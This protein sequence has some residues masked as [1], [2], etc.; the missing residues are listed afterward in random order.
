MTVILIGASYRDIPLSDLAKLESCIETIRTKL[1][2]DESI[3]HGIDGGVVVSTC[4]RFEIYLD[5]YLP[6]NATAHVIDCIAQAT[7]NS[8]DFWRHGIKVLVGA[9]AI[10]HLF[11]VSAGLDS[12]VVG[13]VEIA[14]QIKRALA[15]TQEL[16]Q[17][18][19]ITEAL[20]QRAALVSKK[21]ANRTNLGATGRSLISSAL[22]L[23]E[24]RH[25][26]LTAKTVL[27][28]GTGAYARVVIAALG[29]EEVG[30][31]FVYSPSGRA[32]EFSK[33]HQTTPISAAQFPQILHRVDL[34]ITCSGTH[35]TLIHTQDLLSAPQLI[36]PMIDLS[37]SPDIEDGVKNLSHVAVINLEEIYR[38]APEEHHETLALAEQII[39]EAVVEFQDDLAA[40]ANDPLVKALRGHVQ[41]I[42]IREVERV[43]RKNGDEIANQVERSLQLV[44]KT[45]FHKPTIHAKTTARSGEQ[46]E[47]QKAIEILFGIEVEKG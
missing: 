1:F 30:T 34:I 44:T 46:D 3:Q 19:R 5:V 7:G 2:D 35:G 42:V 40:R 13:E 38:N 39:E 12:M 14:G 26:A 33:S 22:T 20:F 11:K 8:V 47:Y 27:V 4:N 16:G 37:L 43:R 9:P 6:E 28:I 21:V 31:I 25:F 18:C 32:E 41:E 17:T 29:R 15:E 36:L 45:I 24:Q 10:A 23:V